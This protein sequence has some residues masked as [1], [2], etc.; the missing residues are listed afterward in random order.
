MQ[1]E[2]S[3][4]KVTFISFHSI[5]ID[6]NQSENSNNNIFQTICSKGATEV[7]K[8]DSKASFI[9]NSYFSKT[10]YAQT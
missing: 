2:E 7:E 3:D 6:N 1:I 10:F 8:F 4:S 5:T 9:D